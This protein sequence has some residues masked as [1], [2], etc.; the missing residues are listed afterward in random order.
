MTTEE[1]TAAAQH[2][3]I[4]ELEIAE[5]ATCERSLMMSDTADSARIIEAAGAISRLYLLELD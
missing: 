1:I 4:C 3:S 2:V 5:C